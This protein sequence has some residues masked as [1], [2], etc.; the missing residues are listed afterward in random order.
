MLVR[1]PFQDQWDTL[2]HQGLSEFD[3]SLIL[4]CDYADIVL[5]EGVVITENIERLAHADRNNADAVREVLKELFSLNGEGNFLHAYGLYCI[6]PCLIALIKMKFED[7]PLTNNETLYQILKVICEN[8]GLNYDE[9]DSDP[10]KHLV[11]LRILSNCTANT[12]PSSQEINQI[13][14][15]NQEILR[16]EHYDEIVNKLGPYL[17]NLNP[18]QTHHIA[19]L[20]VLAPPGGLGY[21]HRDEIEEIT[22]RIIND[23]LIDAMIAGNHECVSELLSRQDI[24]EISKNPYLLIKKLSW[25]NLDE[26]QASYCIDTLK[27]L[28]IFNYES[29]EDLMHPDKFISFKSCLSDLQNNEP[30]AKQFLM[31]YI[32]NVEDA[33]IIYQKLLLLSRSF[34]SYTILIRQIANIFEFDTNNLM[35]AAMQKEGECFKQEGVKLKSLL[36]SYPKGTFDLTN[37]HPETKQTVLHYIAKKGNYIHTSEAEGEAQNFLTINRNCLFTRDIEGKFPAD[38]AFVWPIQRETWFEQIRLLLLAA[39]FDTTC[40]LNN[41]HDDLL[42]LIAIWTAQVHCGNKSL[43]DLRLDQ[44]SLRADRFFTTYNKCKDG[45]FVVEEKEKS[46]CSMQ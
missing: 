24:Q 42:I 38:I 37:Q 1:S 12:L 27:Q 19:A 20:C 14:T 11:D 18:K 3:I 43:S 32:K 40:N 39:R 13:I 22:Q 21:F 44:K 34:I 36:E 30:L 28:K 33:E 46:N 25:K 4:L 7:K 35:H 9:L 41:I 17:F 16:T 31:A 15:E 10:V 23:Y 5:R 45:E 29:P 26:I 8:N 6:V 2:R